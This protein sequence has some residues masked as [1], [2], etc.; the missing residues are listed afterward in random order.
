MLKELS[1]FPM[2]NFHSKTLVVDS[3]SLKGNPLG[4]SCLR[5]N[6]VLIPKGQ[7]EKWPVVLILAGFTG[8]GPKYFSPKSYESNFPQSLDIC[9]SPKKSP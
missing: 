5:Y 3:N 4:D 9:I 8:N 1:L 6:P 7:G 2:D